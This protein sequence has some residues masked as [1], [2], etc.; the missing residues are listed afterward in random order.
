MGDWLDGLRFV[1]WV[2]DWPVGLR[3]VRIFMGALWC[4]LLYGRDKTE[5]RIQ[6]IGP[7]LQV[8]CRNILLGLLYEGI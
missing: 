3:I 4:I 8:F 6:Y 5:C 2:G 1:C 7:V